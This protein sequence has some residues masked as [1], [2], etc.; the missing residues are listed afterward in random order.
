MLP[1]LLG[2]VAPK[3]IQHRYKHFSSLAFRDKCSKTLLIEAIVGFACEEL[4]SF[5]MCLN[6][7]GLSYYILL[8]KKY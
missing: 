3:F 1:S 7:A 4:T 5:E 6:R 8:I 2:R